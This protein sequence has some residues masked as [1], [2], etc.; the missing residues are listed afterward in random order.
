MYVKVL[1]LLLVVLMGAQGLAQSA[2]DSI[3]GVI[4]SQLQ[5]FQSDDFVTAFTFASPVI[6]EIFSTPENFGRMVRNGFP[7]VHRPAD[8]QFSSLTERAGRQYQSVLIKD[9]SGRLHVLEY[10]MI[11]GP[12]GWQINGVQFKKPSAAGA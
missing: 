6:R 3:R 5:A 12:D 10:E 11:E 8:V 7:M 4:S 2:S 9:Q 1:G